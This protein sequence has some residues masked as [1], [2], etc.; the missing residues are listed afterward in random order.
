MPTP[1]GTSAP[2]LAKQPLAAHLFPLQ[3]AT[4]AAEAILTH[5]PLLE[6]QHLAKDEKSRRGQAPC[7]HSQHPTESPISLAPPSSTGRSLHCGRIIDIVVYIFCNPT[8]NPIATSDRQ[9]NLLPIIAISPRAQKVQP[10]LPH[11]GTSRPNSYATTS[12]KTRQD[13]T[14]D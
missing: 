14:F 4:S 11:Q 6:S 9:L 8:I 10:A 1:R 13:K 5:T 12:T 2:G 3:R 7:H